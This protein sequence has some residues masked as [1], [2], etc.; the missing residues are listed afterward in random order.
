MC[1]S[2][3]L[4]VGGKGGADALATWD[5]RSVEIRMIVIEHGITILPPFFAIRN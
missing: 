5:E 2:A 3:S 4:Y 1:D